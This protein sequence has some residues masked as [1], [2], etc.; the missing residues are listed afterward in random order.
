VLANPEGWTFRE[1][2]KDHVIGRK[3]ETFC[4]WLFD[5]LG[6]EAEDDFYDLFPGSGA[7]MQAWEK[8]RAQPYLWHRVG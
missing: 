7:V 5:C 6:L 8:F 4:F 3:P 1:M 2:P